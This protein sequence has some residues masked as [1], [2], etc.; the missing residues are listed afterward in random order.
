MYSEDLKH[1][2]NM[3]E[4]SSRFI[5][6]SGLAGVFAGSFALIASFIAYKILGSYDV[7]NYDVNIDYWEITLQLI[8]LA[9]A[10]LLSSLIAGIIVTMRKSK[11]QNL[12]IWTK[13]TFLMLEA[14]AIPLFS[15]G[16]MCL[17][18]LYWGDIYYIAPATLIFYG[19]ALINASKYTFGDVKY[20]GILEIFLGLIALY[21]L[22]YGLI[23]WAIGFGFLHIL[24][25]FIMHVK[26]K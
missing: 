21:F 2:R 9:F 10:T 3:M 12:V 1:I 13:S 4:K 8:G 7:R 5:S 22:G 24:Y 23:F 18:F 20:L 16:I 19:L 6:L 26:Y 11:K 15:G 25:G 17:A 14:L